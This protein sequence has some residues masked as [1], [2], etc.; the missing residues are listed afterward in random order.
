[1]NTKDSL[2]RKSPQQKTRALIDALILPMI[3]VVVGLAVGGM[4]IAFSGSNPFEAIWGLLKGGYGSTYLIFT[5]LTRATPIIFAGLSAAF[6]WGSGY[7]SMGIGGQMTA[8]ALVAA[9]VG[10]ACPGPAVVVIL[11]SMAAGAFAGF[12]YSLIPTWLNLK[13]EASLLIVTLMLNY[14]AD[15]LSTY[16]TTYVFKDVNGVDSSAVQTTE[17]AAALPKIFSQYSLHVG[18]LL[19]LLFVAGMCFLKDRT[20][21]GYRARIGGLNPQFAD[22]G[23]INS[24]KMTYWV[25]SLSAAVAGLGGAVEVLGTK[26]RFVDQM[27]TSPGFA[28]SGITASI[29]ANYNPVGT[30]VSCIFLAGLN[31]GGSYIERNMGIPGEV[32]SIIQGVITMLVTIKLVFHLKKKHKK[33]EEE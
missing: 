5:T 28:W 23:G 32:S 10:A 26:H 12:A 30:L 11:V 8:G 13:F 4:I 19:A 16:F 31:T 1:M 14:V 18:F 29:M 3:A 33:Q 6:V 7:E 20:V 2:I 25:L 9:V 22:Y 24:T 21:F 15:Y 27:M 17:M